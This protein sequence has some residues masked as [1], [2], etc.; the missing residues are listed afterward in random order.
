M[1]D[2]VTKTL[3][4]QPLSNRELRAK[5]GFSVAEADPLLD[6]T[7]QRLRREKRIRL[8]GNRWS[9]DTIQKCPTCGGCGWLDKR[10]RAVD[11]A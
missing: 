9:A 4:E 11:N 8:E 7:L 2:V 3:E 10:L 5:L 6:R 1:D